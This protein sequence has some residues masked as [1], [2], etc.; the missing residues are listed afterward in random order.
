[1]C[2]TS[3]NGV[4]DSF[5]QETLERLSIAEKIMVCV[6][7]TATTEKTWVESIKDY[8]LKGELSR[9]LAEVSLIKRRS[10]NHAIIGG[11]LQKRIVYSPFEMSH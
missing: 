3:T 8:I 5:I 2:D 1:M 7:S 11:T 10:S 4:T 6:A 9:K